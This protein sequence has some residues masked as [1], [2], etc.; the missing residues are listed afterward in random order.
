M[1][2]TAAISSEAVRLMLSLPGLPR[3]TLRAFICWQR[4][5]AEKVY[6]MRF[7]QTDAARFRIKN[8]IDQHLEIV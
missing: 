7:D 1:R 2:S 6:G 3:L 4:L 8:W 5:G